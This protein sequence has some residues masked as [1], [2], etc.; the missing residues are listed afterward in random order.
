MKTDREG[1]AGGIVAGLCRLV[2]QLV[3]R[4]R[5][6]CRGKLSC[7]FDVSRHIMLLDDGFSKYF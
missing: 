4:W 2:L 5:V 6:T 1:G 7:Q 3:K